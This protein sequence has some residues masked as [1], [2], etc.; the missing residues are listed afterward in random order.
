MGSPRVWVNY[1]RV[2]GVPGSPPYKGSRLTAPQGKGAGHPGL[3]GLQIPTEQE[4]PAHGDLQGWGAQSFPIVAQVQG[5]P[6][7]TTKKTPSFALRGSS[8]LPGLPGFFPG[9]R[10][11]I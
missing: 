2:S 6:W 5:A 9:R 4:L 1:N 11:L 3:T 7:I 8:L 10:G